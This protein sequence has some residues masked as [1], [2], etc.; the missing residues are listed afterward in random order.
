MGYPGSGKSAVANQ[1]KEKYGYGVVCRDELKTWEKVV[2]KAKEMLKAKKSV[3]VDCTNP[4]AAS[5]Y[6]RGKWEKCDSTNKLKM[7]A[8]KNGTNHDSEKF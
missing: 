3:I 5:R 8:Q 4:D 6:V 2:A 1:L 7:T